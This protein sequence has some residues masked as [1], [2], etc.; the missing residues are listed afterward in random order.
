[1]QSFDD[2]LNKVEELNKKYSKLCEMLTY[3]EVFLDKKLCLNIEKQKQNLQPLAEKFEEYLQKNKTLQEINSLQNQE[4]KSLFEEEIKDI[5]KEIDCLRNDIKKLYIDLNAKNQNIIVEITKTK[6]E[7]SN[8][9][10][11][12]LILS[13]ANFCKNND[14]S[15]DIKKEN[16]SLQLNISGF[17]AKV[18]FEEEIGQVKAVDQEKLGFCSIFIFDVTSLQEIVFCEEDVKITTCRSSGAGGQYI[19]TTDSSIKATHIP[20]NITA[21]SQDERSQ[22]QNKQKAIERL[23]QKVLDMAKKQKE[24]VLLKQK[25]EQIKEIKTKAIVREINYQTQKVKSKNQEV[26]LSDFLNGKIL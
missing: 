5:N 24:E 7:L 14:L 4:E 11:E 17:N 3:E 6:D 2:I 19:N 10:F 22:F 20:T 18:Y 16:S 12:D 8:K 23:K 25:K 15:C 9:L 26:L 13:Y 1:M 21:V